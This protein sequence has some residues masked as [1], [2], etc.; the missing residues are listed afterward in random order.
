MPANN[1]LAAMEINLFNTNN[2]ESALKPSLATVKKTM[3][4]PSLTI[5]PSLRMM[6]INALPAVHNGFIRSKPDFHSTKG[7]YLHVLNK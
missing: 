2:R 3:T 1:E 5:T 4:I 7:I 6:T